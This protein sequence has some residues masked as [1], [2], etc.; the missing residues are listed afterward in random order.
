RGVGGGEVVAVGLD[1]GL[2]LRGEV[3]HLDRVLLVLLLQKRQVRPDHRDRLVHPRHLIVQVTDVLLEDQVRVLGAR[4]GEGEQAA[5]CWL[6]AFPHGSGH[7]REVAAYHT[8][9]G[10]GGLRLSSDAGRKASGSR[11]PRRCSA[12]RPCS[13]SERTGTSGE[14]CSAST[15]RH[16]P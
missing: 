15:C 2:H 16:P 4:G 10:G 13:V 1:G 12:V 9:R 6:E 7:P 14:P 11:A 8:S 5:H 3:V